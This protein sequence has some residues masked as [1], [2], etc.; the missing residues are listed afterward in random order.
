[1]AKERLNTLERL[2]TVDKSLG[3]RWGR[4]KK[5]SWAI[6]Q[7]AVA[8]GAAYWV[9]QHIFGH[10]YPFFAPIAAVIILGMTGGDRL[11]RAVEMSLGCIVGVGLGDLIVP[12]LGSG[13]W[14]IAVAVAIALLFG[15]FL[16]KSQL[17][18]NQIAIGA[19]L[20]ATIMP[21][22]MVSPGGTGGP[23]RMMDAVIGSTVGILVIA[24]IP[25]NPLSAGRQE[26]S[27][28]MAIASSV[29]DDVANALQRRDARGL[30]NALQAVRDTQGD[31][32][33]MLDS[34]KVG[35]EAS[36]I[37]PLF[38][39]SRS[40]V[41]SLERILGP[42]DNAV[43]NV[44][45]LARRSRV[46]T[47]DGDT[48]AD[49]QIEIIEELAGILLT[50]SELYERGAEISEAIEI[51]QMVNQLRRLGSRAD[52]SLVEGRVLSAHVVLAQTRSI[53]VD[54]LQICGMSRAS[55][56]AV[57]SPTSQTPAY[58]PEVWDGDEKGRD[59]DDA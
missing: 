23:E 3:S 41:R 43:R 18:N 50:F 37:S 57:L 45:V 16:S 39:T 52:M 17:V 6:T 9:A 20:I 55:S 25:D 4:V 29:L 13:P 38:W 33:S 42:V 11:R 30:A 10:Q 22:G 15:S 24:I 58:P 54:L 48:V 27:K 59:A 2:R 35:R 28:V 46:L 32:N 47:E 7:Q 36:T 51:P 19:I 56:L 49:E 40:R 1:M 44:R 31:I 5:R 12:L 53:I 34:A 8:A 21:P 26:I 14:Q